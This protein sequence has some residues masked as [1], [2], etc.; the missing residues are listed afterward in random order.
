MATRRMLVY[1]PELHQHGAPS[2]DGWRALA[3]E[4]EAVSFYSAA[5]SHEAFPKLFLRCLEARFEIH[6]R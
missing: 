2:G 4:I 3:G 6:L 5:Q 1:S